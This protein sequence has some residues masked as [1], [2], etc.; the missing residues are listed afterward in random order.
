MKRIVAITFAFG[1]LICG[2]A[3]AIPYKLVRQR[4]VTTAQINAFFQVAVDRGAW[5]GVNTDI[6]E[7]CGYRTTSGGSVRVIGNRSGSDTQMGTDR[8]NSGDLVVIE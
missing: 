3:Y 8:A 5:P 4:N 6:T 1:L 2:I 7:L